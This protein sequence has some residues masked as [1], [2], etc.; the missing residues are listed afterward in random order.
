MIEYTRSRLF[1]MGGAHIDR[2]GQVSVPYVPGASNP[3]VMHEEAGG[4]AFNAIRTIVQRDVPVGILS[5]RGGDSAGDAVARAIEAAGISDH[6]VTFMDRATPSYTAILDEHGDVVSALADMG[7]YDLAF[8]KQLRR[9]STRDL[10]AEADALFCDANMPARALERLIRLAGGK[11]VYALAIS[12]AKIGRLTSVLDA[13]AC[14]FMNRRE[15]LALTTLPADASTHR[16]VDALRTLGLQSAVIS[17]GDGALLGFRD[18]NVHEVLP[19]AVETIVDVTGAGD[20]MAGGIVAAL[21]KG[22]AFP[23]ALREGLAAS[24]LTVQ[25][26]HATPTFTPARFNDA[27]AHIPPAK[28]WVLQPADQEG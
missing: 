13:L 16:I 25:T 3:G 8:E 6:S 5:V 7:L 20:A 17:H 26:A 21:M 11:P 19:P 2:R 23:D 12:P 10:V 18:G 24:Y 27:M 28:S 15:A 22:I 14:V 9:R 4:G 1:A